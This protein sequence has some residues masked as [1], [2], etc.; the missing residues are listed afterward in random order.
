MPHSETIFEDLFY[1]ATPV[2]N[3]NYLQ[4]FRVGSI[5]DQERVDRKELYRLIRQA[6]A[7]MSGA[8]IP[9][10]KDDLVSNDRF[11]AIRYL[12]AALSPDVAPDFDKIE[13][14]FWRKNVAPSHSGLAFRS[15]R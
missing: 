7:P 13:R 12:N 10:Q 9:C 6:P 5:D 11:N 14:G 8:G 3:G 2:K 4:W 1:V 15:A